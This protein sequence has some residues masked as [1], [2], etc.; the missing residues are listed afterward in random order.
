MQRR[1]NE[2]IGKL[3]PQGECD[4]TDVGWQEVEAELP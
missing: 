2:V 3:A 4:D 1:V